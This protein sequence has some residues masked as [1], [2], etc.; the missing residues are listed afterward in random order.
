MTISPKRIEEL[1]M[2]PLRTVAEYHD[3]MGY[4][5]SNEDPY[6]M[7]LRH[8]FVMGVKHVLFE[9][10][11]Y[12]DDCQTVPA[13]YAEHYR[14]G[15][16]KGYEEG[17]DEGYTEGYEVSLEENGS[18]VLQ[19]EIEE[20]KETIGELRSKI[21]DQAAE[22]G[23]IKRSVK[24]LEDELWEAMGKIASQTKE[25]EEARRTISGRT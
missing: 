2:L 21:K 17:C 6:N 4:D 13:E 1:A 24:D 18:E 8:G 15:Y 22:I 12:S 14:N 16:N 10:N 20:A 7:G 23:E 11:F 25:L 9:I 5:P 3:P 19:F